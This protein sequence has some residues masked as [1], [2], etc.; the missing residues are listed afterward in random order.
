MRCD[1]GFV[2]GS[3]VFWAASSANFFLLEESSNFSVLFCISKSFFV[4][5]VAAFGDLFFVVYRFGGDAA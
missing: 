5:D 2:I 3:V 4:G 1:A